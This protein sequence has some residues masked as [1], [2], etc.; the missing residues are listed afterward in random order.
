MI[1]AKKIMKKELN[2]RERIRNSDRPSSQ[3]IRFAI[4]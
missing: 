3:M 4:D 2:G 1:V